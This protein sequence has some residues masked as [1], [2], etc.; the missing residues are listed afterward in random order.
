VIRDWKTGDSL[1]YAFIEFE[2]DE[3]CEQAYFKMENVLID[4]RRIHVDFSQSVSKLWGSY[5]RGD[6][7]MKGNFSQTG[8]PVGPANSNLVLR[9]GARKRG[10]GRESQHQLIFEHSDTNNDR[11]RDHGSQ[12]KK[13]ERETESDRRKKN[14]KRSRSGSGS[15]GRRGKDK[16]RA[17]GKSPGKQKSGKKKI[18]RNR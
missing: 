6:K 4:D 10:S 5:R 18:L 11:K 3:Q 14:K 8:Q 15:R 16:E 1:Q 13:E 17:R 12:R 2:S 9:D 7:D